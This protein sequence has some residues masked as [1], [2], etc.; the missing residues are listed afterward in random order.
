MEELADHLL[1]EVRGELCRGGVFAAVPVIVPNKSIARFL[2]LRFARNCGIAAGLEFPFLMSLFE[3][4]NLPGGLRDETGG[5]RSGDAGSLVWRVLAVLPE[6][7]RRGVMPE[8]LHSAGHNQQYLFAC[9]MAGLFDRYLLYRPDLILAWEK[10][11][12]RSDDWQA[13]LWRAVTAEHF[14]GRHFAAVWQGIQEGKLHLKAGGPVRIFGFAAIPPAILRCLEKFA[15][16][17]PVE[18]YCLVPSR[19]FFGDSK[20]GRKE[21]RELAAMAASLRYD[22]ETFREV[23]RN[24]YFQHHVLVA[25]LASQ[26]R[27]LL[28]ETIDW[29][30][31]ETASAPPT[32]DSLLRKLQRWIMNDTHEPEEPAP[33]QPCRSIQIR[34][35]CSILREAE[36]AH[37][38]LLH[39]FEEIPGLTPDDVL[40]MSPTPE[41]YA[42]LVD[43]VFNHPSGGTRLAVSIA[44]RAP[45]T[46]WRALHT[47]LRVLTLFRGHFSATE[48]FAVLQDRDLQ[49]HHRLTPEDCRFCMKRAEAAGIRWGFDA[50]EHRGAGGVAF[51]E[52]SWRAGLDRLLLD[53]A[54][55][56][57]SA[58]PYEAIFPVAGFEGAR[59]VLLGKFAGLVTKLRSIA[60]RMREAEEYGWKFDV[61][62][63][64]LLDAQ[65]ALFGSE[66]E[67]AGL[68]LRFLNQWEEA[69]AG[70]RAMELALTGEMI[71]HRFRA[72]LETP[73]DSSRGFR[74]GRITFCSL[75]PMRNIPARV[76]VLMGMNHDVFPAGSIRQDIDHLARSPRPGDPDA[77]EDSRQLFLDL[78][79]S[80]RDALYLSYLGR[81]S[82]DGK[83]FPPSVC[84]EEL[85]SC[86]QANFG[87]QCLTE[88]EEPL[89][90]YVPALFEPGAP[91]QSYSP[92][93]LEAARAVTASGR[94][95]GPVF[96]PGRLSAPAPELLEQ[97]TL[98]ELLSF[99]RNPAAFF[100]KKRLNLS[101]R[102]VAEESIPDA[103]PLEES[104]LDFDRQD[105]LLAQLRRTPETQWPQLAQ[106]QLARGKADGVLPYPWKPQNWK[107]FQ[108]F[109]ALAKQL[110]PDGAT[111]PAREVALA[112]DGASVRLELP[113]IVL[114]ADGVQ[115]WSSALEKLTG[116]TVLRG[117]IMHLG[118]NLTA[119]TGGAIVLPG[120]IYRMAA[121]GRDEAAEKMRTLLELYR[122]GLCEPLCFFPRT[123]YALYSAP[124]GKALEK[125][126][127]AWAKD[128]AQYGMIF[129]ALMPDPDKI[130]A[131]ARRVF[132]TVKFQSDA[133]Q[134]GEK[135][136]EH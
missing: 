136:D 70:A 128:E 87:E 53:Y 23:L 110:P 133:G 24:C 47:F 71:V 85:R 96:A 95:A 12:S 48:V 51:A 20:P 6:L 106:T 44:D 54:L 69:L 114:G 116:F 108:Q 76:I 11:A 45:G 13:A 57:D 115:Y 125:A 78:I 97:V 5:G 134:T 107:E 75:R 120:K 3:E 93:M 132:D 84:V 99:F 36:A 19:E 7:I 40:M 73:A 8:Q 22:P 105:E 118:A 130:S 18:L 131:I 63:E 126:E 46:E 79:L 43:A 17:R 56:S 37:N 41:R 31:G 88:L 26:A 74:R 89:Q 129:G 2:S 29:P 62:K 33:A 55:E 52:T 124:E 81:S 90:A 112:G 59:G 82:H 65:E 21:L 50:E 86:L 72:F 68:L 64:F 100:L 113:E 123:S 91:N 109:A 67:A 135:S 15:S 28:H 58:Q 102:L 34:S 121:L 111:L 9:K 122:E 30:E 92:A 35:C 60:R 27:T 101:L 119:P 127:E 10:G 49:T 103:E 104:Y 98:E 83:H 117:L 14:A 94:E 1:A 25:A 32:G 39:C 4:K 38:Y 80:A 66:S 42:P 61:W 77:R 16:A